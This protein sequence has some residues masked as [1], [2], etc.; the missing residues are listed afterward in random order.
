MNIPYKL[1]KS[2]LPCSFQITTEST[3]D[4]KKYL[5]PPSEIITIGYEK[6]VQDDNDIVSQFTQNTPSSAIWSEIP[7]YFMQIISVSEEDF[8]VRL[9]AQN[10]DNDGNRKFIIKEMRDDGKATIDVIPITVKKKALFSEQD[11]NMDEDH[12]NTYHL[13]LCDSK[14]RDK[15]ITNSNELK[16]TVLINESEYPPSNTNYKPNPIDTSTVIRCKDVN[17]EQVH[18]YWQVPSDSFGNI[19]YKILYDDARDQ[20]DEGKIES[21]TITNLPYSV[22]LSSIPISIRVIT[23]ANVEDEQYESD[24]SGIITVADAVQIADEKVE[25]EMPDDVMEAITNIS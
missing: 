9:S 7:S 12:D 1:S 22:P 16:F 13:V 24:P 3:I 8:V 20:D 2:L 4:D 11:G 19:S 15:L 17:N 5:S 14:N 10:V 25:I 21:P 18:I 6:S 23:I